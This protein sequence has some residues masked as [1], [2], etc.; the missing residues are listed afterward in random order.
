MPESVLARFGVTFCDLVHSYP[1][2]AIE[3]GLLTVSKKNQVNGFARKILEIDGL[4]TLK[5]EQ[6]FELSGASAGRTAVG[7]TFM[8]V[9]RMFAEY[10]ILNITMLKWITAEEY[11]DTCTLQRG[12]AF[13]A[14]P[15]AKQYATFGIDFST[16]TILIWCCRGPRIGRT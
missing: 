14:D 16:I 8:L 12:I 9:K 4:G 13:E 6:P 11:G 10:M 7:C 2:V 5:F 15:A 1:R 3:E